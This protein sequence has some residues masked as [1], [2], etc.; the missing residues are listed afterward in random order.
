M[1]ITELG[2]TNVSSKHWPI[3]MIL[4]MSS[5][6]LKYHHR[7]YNGEFPHSDKAVDIARARAGR[8]KR[9][10]LHPFSC[11]PRPPARL[12]NPLALSG[13]APSLLPRFG[14]A[15]S[16]AAF[17]GYLPSIYVTPL[18]CQNLSFVSINLNTVRVNAQYVHTARSLVDRL[19][20]T[21]T[22]LVIPEISKSLFD[23]IY[24]P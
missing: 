20:P 7:N 19:I 2:N 11:H 4:K 21:L 18:A 1:R 13:L 10:P 8:W 5:V 15:P 14:L 3:F 6:N 12:H 9:L 17:T 16:L 24:A 23:G 22:Y